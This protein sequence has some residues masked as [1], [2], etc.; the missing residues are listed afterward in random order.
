MFAE[1]GKYRLGFRGFYLNN[2]ADIRHESIVR[3]I[4]TGYFG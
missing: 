2:V 1:F 3:K 4:L